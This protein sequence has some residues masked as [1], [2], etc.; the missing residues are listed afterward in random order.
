MGTLAPWDANRGPRSQDD[1]APYEEWEVLFRK[2]LLL[3]RRLAGLDTRSGARP[4]RAPDS[5]MD[6]EDEELSGARYCP[7]CWT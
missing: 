2:E 7:P 3:E 1:R 4:A 6:Q 5:S